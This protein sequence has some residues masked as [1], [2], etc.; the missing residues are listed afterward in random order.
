MGLAGVSVRVV[1]AF[2]RNFVSF[3]TAVLIVF[4]LKGWNK[5][6]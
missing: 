5:Y 6:S 2:I 3:V 1:S 4:M